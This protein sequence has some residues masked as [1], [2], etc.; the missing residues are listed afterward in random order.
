MSM[1]KEASPTDYMLILSPFKA[2][3][4]QEFSS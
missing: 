4:G 3:G 1:I 2:G